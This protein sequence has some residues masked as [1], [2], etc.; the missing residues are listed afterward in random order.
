MVVATAAHVSQRILASSQI[1]TRLPLC[2]SFIT[3]IVIRVQASRLNR[4]QG[5]LVVI[6]RGLF[7]HVTLILALG[8]MPKGPQFRT[9][10]R[11][12]APDER[13]G[14]H[15]PS[16]PFASQPSLLRPHT[17]VS[18][19]SYY[20]DICPFPEKEVRLS[21]CRVLPVCPDVDR[22]ARM[23]HASFLPLSQSLRAVWRGGVRRKQH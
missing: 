4:N 1:R 13:S 10:P 17:H 8:S 12:P 19:V 23:D 6:Y 14:D 3:I 9:T 22:V 7:G 18:I 20:P 15:L 5:H 21:S 11:M 16:Q 2:L